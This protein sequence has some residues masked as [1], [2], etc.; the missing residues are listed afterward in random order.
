M[1]ETLEIIAGKVLKIILKYIFNVNKFREIPIGILL[2]IVFIVFLDIWYIYYSVDLFLT[3]EEMR[4]KILALSPISLLVLF[5]LSLTFSSLVIVPYGFL[6]RKNW[7]RIFAL[8]LLVE[9]SLGAISYI[10]TTKDIILRYPLFVIYVLFIMYLL[11]SST[12]KYFAKTVSDLNA[13]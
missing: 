13:E 9:S 4:I 1:L 5:D 12:K 10:I 7:T 3:Y 2:F 11:M 6:T 8:V